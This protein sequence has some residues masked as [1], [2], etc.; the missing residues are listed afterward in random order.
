MNSW[1]DKTKEDVIEDISKAK[2]LLQF[3]SVIIKGVSYMLIPHP[4]TVE[5]DKLKYIKNA[6]Q[7]AKDNG[8]EGVKYKPAPIKDYIQEFKTSWIKGD[9]K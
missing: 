2:K 9:T 3:E 6:F 1:K 5:H 8:F 7:L 4:N